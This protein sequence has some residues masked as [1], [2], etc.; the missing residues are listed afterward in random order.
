M[1]IVVTPLDNQIGSGN[2][3]TS[4]SVSVVNGDYL[5]VCAAGGKASAASDPITSMAIDG[6]ALTKLV[7]SVPTATFN[8]LDWFHCSIWGLKVTSSITGTIVGSCAGGTDNTQL[9][10]AA[11]KATG[12]D[13]VTPV[14]D[15]DSMSDR[16]GTGVPRSLTVT[17][18]AGDVVFDVLSWDSSFSNDAI[19]DG[20]QTA[21]YNVTS[22]EAG[23]GASYKAASGS[24]T[25][26]TWTNDIDF[27]FRM[28]A[29][30]LSQAAGGGGGVLLKPQMPWR[31]PV[32]AQ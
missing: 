8:S 3:I 2:S 1:A 24:S 22:S 18:V 23:I 15:T 9:Y 7:E 19:P 13:S 12:V 11:V 28:C 17:T 30:V 26:M 6:N 25:A 29:A 16:T 5:L 14:G 4:D 31:Q 27:T 21:I 20:S 32:F 10:L